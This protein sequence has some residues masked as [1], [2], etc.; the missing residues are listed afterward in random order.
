MCANYILSGVLYQSDNSTVIPS[1]NIYVN[2]IS[3]GESHNGGDAGYADLLTD[4]DGNWSVNLDSFTNDFSQGD[5]I[6]I[7]SSSS[8]Y[9][10]DSVTTTVSGDDGEAG[11]RIVLQGDEQYNVDRVID[12]LGEVV[13]YRTVVQTEDSDSFG[14][15]DSE[16][17]ADS[18]IKGYLNI[19]E[20]RTPIEAEGRLE[21]GEADFIC[22]IR[23]SPVRGA[24]IRVPRT[25]GKWFRI[26]D[27]PKQRRKGGQGMFYVM[28]VVLNV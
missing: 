10:K 2:N 20:D 9:G 25:T 8:T 22:R 14:S 1:V 4:E 13:D 23:D 15:V 12:K 18:T 5:K 28:R 11:I 16:S 24:L 7:S 26:I 6:E 27:E 3:K 19:E 17:T 21:E